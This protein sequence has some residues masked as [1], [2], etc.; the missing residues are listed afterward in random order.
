[1]VKALSRL[2]RT[3][4]FEVRGFTSVPAFI[5]ACRPQEAACLVLDV[6]MPE[7][8]GLELQKQL[9]RQGMLIPIILDLPASSSV[10][11]AGGQC[12][13]HLGDELRKSFYKRP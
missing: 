5:E 2:L 10:D 9:T 6:A 7:L 13:F 4:R 1:M 3:E 8:D 12:R 11:G